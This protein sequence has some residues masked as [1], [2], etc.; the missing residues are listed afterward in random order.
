LLVL[1]ARFCGRNEFLAWIVHYVGGDFLVDDYQVVA[2]L[3]VLVFIQRE[4]V[5]RRDTELLG[6]SYAYGEFALD[7]ADFI[8]LVL[9]YPF[10]SEEQTESYHDDA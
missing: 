4:V 7:A 3:L 10:C 5:A 8:F 9:D 1:A 6:V 2:V